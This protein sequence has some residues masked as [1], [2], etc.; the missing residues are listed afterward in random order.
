MFDRNL[1]LRSRVSTQDKYSLIR[2]LVLGICVA[3]A[4]YARQRKRPK[5]DL[6]K[7]NKERERIQRN[8][9]HQLERVL[10]ELR[11][12]GID[13]DLDTYSLAHFDAIAERHPQFR[14]EIYTKPHSGPFYELQHIANSY[15]EVPVMIGRN[16][17]SYD[18]IRPSKST[19]GKY[20]CKSCNELYSKQSKHRC[21]HKCI[22]CKWYF[23]DNTKIRPQKCPKCNCSFP[24]D[25][26]FLRHITLQKGHRLTACMKFRTCPTC[27]KYVD[28]EAQSG[29][30][31]D[32]EN[33]DWCVKCR[34]YMNKETHEC[35][36]YPPSDEDK[37]RFKRK[38]NEWS[39]ICFD[40]ETSQCYENE[41]G[42]LIDIAEHYVVCI[43]YQK[44]CNQCY[45][46]PL[47]AICLK[48]GPKQGV[49]KLGAEDRCDGVPS[50]EVREKVARSFVR[51][52]LKDKRN[53]KVRIQTLFYC[54]FFFRVMLLLTTARDSTF[55]S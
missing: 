10:D 31:H 44:I 48:C 29:Q 8:Q 53:N 7:L 51:F 34:I 37:D 21:Q 39:A 6:D 20:K 15:A 47:D 26:C 43:C 24:N 11:A 50:E 16:G 28:T 42:E 18:L 27:L 55:I 46:Q 13:A 1:G 45:T 2:C 23:C 17:A 33:K 14:F 12:A 38:L 22:F 9:R 4:N 36:F 5:E 52:L 49:F 54:R 32:C 40:A 41:E 35:A 30:Q 25:Q 3:A 19:M